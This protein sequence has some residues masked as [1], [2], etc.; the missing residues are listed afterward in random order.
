MVKQESLWLFFVGV[1]MGVEDVIRFSWDC[2]D[3]KV[4][5]GMVLS[6]RAV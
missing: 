4:D 1:L 5:E 3:V 6:E 2:E